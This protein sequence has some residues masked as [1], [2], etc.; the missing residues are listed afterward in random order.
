MGKLTK[1]RKMVL[2][3]LDKEKIYSL[4]EAAKLV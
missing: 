4:Q 2:A 3:K 1:N